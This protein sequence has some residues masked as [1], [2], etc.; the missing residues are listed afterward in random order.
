MSSGSSLDV[1]P[2]TSALLQTFVPG[3][4]AQQ[5]AS[6]VKALIAWS[7]CLGFFG[8][9]LD[10]VFIWLVAALN[11]LPTAKSETAR[12]VANAAVLG[13]TVGLPVGLSMLAV[14]SGVV[15]AF[16][17][18]APVAF[19]A[20]LDSDVGFMNS[21]ATAIAGAGGGGAYSGLANVFS[22]ISLWMP[23]ATALSAITLT[24]VIKKS[25]IVQYLAA[26]IGIKVFTTV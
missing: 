8:F 21:V 16:M 15:L 10:N 2:F 14:F 23:I 17:L 24:L 20:V 9:V 12:D 22:L 6:W 25:M 26:A 13:N 4:S 3:G 7:I 1:N 18:A 5:I 19:F 11:V